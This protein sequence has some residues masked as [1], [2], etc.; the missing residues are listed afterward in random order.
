MALDNAYEVEELATPKGIMNKMT[1]GADPIGSDW[2]DKTQ[3]QTIDR[4]DAAP[5]HAAR[6]GCVPGIEK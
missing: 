3:R 1:T 5:G 2:S 6:E 4:D